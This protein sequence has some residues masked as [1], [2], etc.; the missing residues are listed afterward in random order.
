MFVTEQERMNQD[1]GRWVERFGRERA[2]ILPVLQEIQ[3]KYHYVSDVAMQVVAD[4]LDIHP[5]EVESVVSFYAFLD[6]KPKGRFVIRLCRTISCDMAG[7]QAVAHRL[8][9]DLGVGFG[10]TTADG[11]FSLEWTNCLGMCDQ[12]PALLVNDVVYTR[13]TPAGV[14]RILDE[15]RR[16][17]GVHALGAREE[18][19]A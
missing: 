1:I 8:Q 10:E 7:K 4:Q 6:E 3:R 9:S 19:H 15:C 11:M 5:V 14:R 18:A 16:T 13:V 12:G 17:F 2:S